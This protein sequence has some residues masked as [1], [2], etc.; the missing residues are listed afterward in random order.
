MAALKALSDAELLSLLRG[1]DELAF[2]EIY[3]RYF[4][5]LYGYAYKKLRDSEKAKDLI[6]EFFATLWLKRCELQINQSVS[7]YFFT[8]VNRRVIDHF[9][10]QEVEDKYVSAFAASP[11]FLN[12]ETD[13]RIRE[14]QLLEL[15]DKEIQ[16][17][18][19]RM[20]EAFELSR[21]E[22]L[23]HKEIAEQMGIAESTVD[24]QISNAL[25]ILKTRLGL[26]AW[27]ILLTRY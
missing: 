7:G 21:K 4:R 19:P 23:S 8:A 2:A 22:H 20:R 24:R 11:V 13:H 27:I 14:K 6:Q 5:P 25:A 26:V 12:A 3:Q 10:H 17:L 16:S 18:P 9:L 15:I 1:D